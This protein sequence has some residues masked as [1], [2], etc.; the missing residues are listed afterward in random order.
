MGKY[1]S[2]LEK[3]L[4]TKLKMDSHPRVKIFFAWILSS[5]LAML[6]T[7]IIS[8]LFGLFSTYHQN[9]DM[10]A[11]FYQSSF[12][13]LIIPLELLTPIGYPN[14]ML[15]VAAMYKKKIIY[16]QWSVLLCLFIGYFWPAIVRAI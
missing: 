5:I 9:E 12:A 6:S 11:Y 2:S 7:A 10:K 15:L 8:V 14:I 13:L 3:Y 16:L 4:H 1:E